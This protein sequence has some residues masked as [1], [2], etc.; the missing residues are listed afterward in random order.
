MRTS[1]G[2]NGCGSLKVLISV[3]A[4]RVRRV[5]KTR[6]CLKNRKKKNIFGKYFWKKL[7]RV[8][9]VSNLVFEFCGLKFR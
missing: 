1:F 7:G 2:K 3:R 5:G 6:C 4:L 9:E 8:G